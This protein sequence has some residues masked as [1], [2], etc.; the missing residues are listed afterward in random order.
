MSGAAKDEQRSGR[1]LPRL[2]AITYRTDQFVTMTGQEL[3]LPLRRPGARA[4]TGASGSRLAA[5]D[6]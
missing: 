1:D 6:F 4:E 2:G 5:W 3:L